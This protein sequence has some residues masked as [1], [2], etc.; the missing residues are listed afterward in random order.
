MTEPDSGQ[1]L[2]DVDECGLQLLEEGAP[3]GEQ[4]GRRLLG[5]AQC[6]VLRLQFFLTLRE[7]FVLARELLQQSLALG[8]R[9]LALC[10]LVLQLGLRRGDLLQIGGHRVERAR[11]IA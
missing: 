8:F 4:A 9:L 6:L 5:L 10:D 7:L 3:L 2:W 11:E 1:F